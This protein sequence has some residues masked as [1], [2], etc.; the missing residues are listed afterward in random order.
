MRAG[1][2]G[3]VIHFQCSSLVEQ[4]VPGSHHGS[5][6][7]RA[8]SDLVNASPLSGPTPDGFPYGN[9]MLSNELRQEVGRLP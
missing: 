5:P 6:F 3:R 2:V 1:I 7:S 9:P 8:C 4:N